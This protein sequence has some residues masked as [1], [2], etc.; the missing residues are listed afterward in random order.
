MLQKAVTIL[1]L[2]PH[3][4]DPIGNSASIELASTQGTDISPDT[5]NQQHLS[6]EARAA[7]KHP[8]ECVGFNL[9]EQTR[10]AQSQQGDLTQ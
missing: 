2:G 10:T 9:Q 5:N 1:S 8:Q 6:T 7:R 3:L 4:Q